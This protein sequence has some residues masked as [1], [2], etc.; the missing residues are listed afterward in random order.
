MQTVE[1]QYKAK[2]TMKQA[3]NEVTFVY[4]M[5]LVKSPYSNDI[6]KGISLLK[7]K[8]H[9]LYMSLFHCTVAKCTTCMA[10]DIVLLHVV[11]AINV[12]SLG[13]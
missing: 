2:H 8:F 3:S 11:V 1:K 12:L 4:A 13:S 5:H 10:N 6:K 9:L 7:G